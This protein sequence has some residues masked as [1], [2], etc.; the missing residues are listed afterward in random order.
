MTKHSKHHSPSSIRGRRGP[1]RIGFI[2]LADCAP[3][4]VADALGFFAKHDVEVELHREVGWA[5][6]REKILYRQIDAAHAVTGLGLS[7]RLGLGG[8]TC[9][10]IA[11]FI[12]NLHGN[13]ITL[14]MD[15]WRR[16]VRDAASLG[17]L[18]RSTPQRLITLGIVARTS[19]HNFMLRR[20]LQS[21]GINPDRDVRLVVLP[22]TQMAGSLAAGLIDGYCVG[23]PWNS[24][25]VAR[26][27]GWCPATSEDLMPGHPEKVLLTTEDYAHDHPAEIRSVIRA[28]YEACQFCDR[29]DNRARVVE[30]LIGSGHVRADRDVL[31]LS[32]IGPFDDGTSRRRAAEN[33]HI[34]H[35]GDANAPSRAKAEWLLGEFITHGLIAP[36]AR[37]HAREEV[38]RCCS[39]ELFHDALTSPASTTRSK[40]K[41]A[42]QP[43]LA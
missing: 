42:L 14:S 5:T 27:I 4:L 28:L 20:W 8:A 41:A 7:L 2:A 13:A 38:L 30:I 43:A 29:M 9:R 26:G 22:P 39:P 31:K 12:F 21:G 24:A 1:V 23:E 33:F 25:A 32:L 6:I 3:L 17:K 40:S 34:F 35:R 10:T 36:E 11:P 37:E 15:L 18:I 16:G 19:T